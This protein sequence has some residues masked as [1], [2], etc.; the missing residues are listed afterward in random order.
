MGVNISGRCAA[1]SMYSPAMRSIRTRGISLSCTA[2]R[3]PRSANPRTATAASRVYSI[4]EGCA[5][6]VPVVPVALSGTD[7][8]NR[9]GRRLL[10]FG[11]VRILFGAP[12]TFPPVDRAAVRTA[13]DEPMVELAMRSGRRYVDCYAAHFRAGSA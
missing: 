13:T 5:H 7:R 6:V 3:A 9:R 1:K 12:R 11:K 10:R 2:K 4:V 8:V